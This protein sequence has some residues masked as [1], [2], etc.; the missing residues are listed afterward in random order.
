MGRVATR[1]TAGGCRHIAVLRLPSLGDVILSLPAVRALAAAFPQARISYWTKEEYAG[2]VRYEPAIQH[3][4][5]LEPDA[6]KLEDLVSMSAELES[7]DLIVDLHGSLRTRLLCFR[8][9]GPVLRAPS[10]RLRPTPSAP[11]RPLPPPPPPP[12]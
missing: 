7:C 11:P 5:V 8:Q 4:R 1:V 12:P 3:L 10:S 2:G 9:P 6:R